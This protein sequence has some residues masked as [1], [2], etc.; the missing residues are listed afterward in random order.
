MALARVR[1]TPCARLVFFSPMQYINLNKWKKATPS[2]NK[3]P[4]IYV[5]RWVNEGEKCSLYF[6]FHL[7]TLLCRN[8]RKHANS[9]ACVRE[10]HLARTQDEGWLKILTERTPWK[11]VHIW[12][13]IRPR[14]GKAHQLLMK[15]FNPLL[16]L[17][18]YDF[19]LMHVPSVHL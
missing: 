19:R 11:R 17:Y 14:M 16:D 7:K 9:D 6:H 8:S 4:P 15:H 12:C 13:T 3:N 5:S 2:R 10:C 1:C 18:I